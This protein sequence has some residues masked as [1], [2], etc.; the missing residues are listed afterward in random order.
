MCR[1]C[2]LS[3]ASWLL[4]CL[5]VGAAE[6]NPSPVAPK[7]RPDVG[8]YAT[9]QDVVEEI[10]KQVKVTKSDRLCDLGCGDGRFVIT[11]AKK[12]HCRAFG[13][14]IDP[15][16]VREGQRRAT[17]AGV[18]DRA[19]IIEQDIFT[20]DLSQMT[21]VTLFLLP[22]LNQRLIPQLEKLPPNA[23]VV[24]HEFE[25]PGL[26]PDR[27]LTYVSKQDD[28]EHLLYFYSLPLKHAVTTSK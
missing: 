21:V 2:L 27:E 24:S 28:S 18:A 1:A 16:L 6:Q 9:T 14:E 7:K 12:Y 15:K 5:L 20:V 17:E 11:A 3:V 23:R 10:L 22:E 19:S 25:I 8:Y 26:I 4:G 13:Y